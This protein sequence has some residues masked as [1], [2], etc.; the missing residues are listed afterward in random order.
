LFWIFFIAVCFGG[1]YLHGSLPQ[2]YINKKIIKLDTPIRIAY[3]SLDLENPKI[4]E[5]VDDRFGNRVVFLQK[6]TLPELRESLKQSP[7][8]DIFIIP[9]EWADLLVKE[10]A[11]R[12]NNYMDF[13]LAPEFNATEFYIPFLWDLSDNNLKRWVIGIRNS[14]PVD[15][16]L[17]Q[18]LYILYSEPTY[19][20]ILTESKLR[21]VLKRLENQAWPQDKKP[22]FIRNIPLE[23]IETKNPHYQAL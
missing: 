4:L 9:I 7:Q 1:G 16:R 18:F 10:S 19:E 6:R 17:L 21:G 12:S 13:S 15:A 5:V 8:P 23:S 11:L 3:S 22:S 2:A 20:R 14:E